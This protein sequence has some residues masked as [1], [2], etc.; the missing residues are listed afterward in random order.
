MKVHLEKPSNDFHSWIFE[1]TLH[2][3]KDTLFLQKD[4]ILLW[5]NSLCTIL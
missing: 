4:R 1:Q 3:S 5:V 2:F